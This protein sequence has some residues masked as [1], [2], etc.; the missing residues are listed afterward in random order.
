MQCPEP[1]VVSSILVGGRPDVVF[2]E[3]R[4]SGQPLIPRGGGTDDDESRQRSGAGDFR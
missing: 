3:H 1:R 2:P 4:G